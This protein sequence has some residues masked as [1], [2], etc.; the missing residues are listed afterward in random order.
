[1][2]IW[3]ESAT[4]YFVMVA[5]ETE[6]LGEQSAAEFLLINA[7]GAILNINGQRDGRLGLPSPYYSP[8]QALRLV[9]KLDQDCREDFVGAAYSVHPLID[10]LVR[11]LRRQALWNLWYPITG[12]SLKAFYPGEVWEWFRWR[13]ETGALN[14]RF[15]GSPQSWSDLVSE[16]GNIDTQLLPRRLRERP[17]FAVFFALV[18]PHRFT[19][20]IL[21]LIEDSL[22]SGS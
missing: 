6:S 10:F 20:E 11:R 5:L 13:A 2:K 4:P 3:G 19:R 16:V 17:A 15:A 18:Y 14:S 7:L 9:Y 1:M 21:K 22:I 12:N 8:E